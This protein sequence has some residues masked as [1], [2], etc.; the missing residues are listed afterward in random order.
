MMAR[1]EQMGLKFHDIRR[2]HFSHPAL[3]GDL[4]AVLERIK[5]GPGLLIMRGFPVDK[6]DAERMQAVYW[7]IGTHFGIGVS[8]S[9]DGDYLGHVTN[10]AK[11]S[12]GYTTDRELHLHTNSAEIVG[13]LCVR[14]A[15]EGGL[16]IYSSSLKVREIIE[17]EHPEYL[18]VLER[19]FRCDRRGEEAP[20]DDPVTPYRVPVFSTRDG[21]LTCRFVRG[22]IDKGAERLGEPLSTIE[23]EALA[24]FEEVAAAR[25][26]ALRGHAA[27]RAR[28]R[29]STITKSCTRAPASSIGTSR[30]RSGCCTG[31]GSRDSR[32]GRWCRRCSSTGTA[33][34]AWASIRSPAAARDKTASRATGP[35]A[36]RP[37]AGGPKAHASMAIELVSASEDAIRRAASL[38][39][40]G[41][42]VAF[43]TETVYG[44][45]G[46][47]TN[48][49][50]VA[51]IFAAKGRPRFNPLIVH[52]PGLEEAEALAV[53][54]DRAR[55]AGGPVLARA[56][57]AGSAA[58]PRR[59][60]VAAGQRRSRYG[61]GARA[62]APGR[63]TAAAC[64]RS[65]DRGAIGQPLRPGQPDDGS[66]SSRIRAAANC[67]QPAT[68]TRRSPSPACGSG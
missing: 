3:D 10:V 59:R 31:S 40:A 35:P 67:P 53:F 15:K 18:P 62:G 6:Y 46:D 36:R 56:A 14:D 13:L 45:G 1:I 47:A 58:A 48:D 65:A 16:S 63:A 30:R 7:G 55:L 9:A 2:E 37:A 42:L 4:A 19:G 61:G 8:Q 44:L 33:P 54:D 38:L 51:A 21:V 60:G 27:A 66:M 39:R 32:R 68:V 12:R 11:A 28:P 26:C 25:R 57:D 22:V 29:S 23:Q 41:A 64:R 5:T 24:C 20:E 52:V 34:A 43:P 50:A 49:R 17:R